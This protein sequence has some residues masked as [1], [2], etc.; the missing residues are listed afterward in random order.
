MRFNRSYHSLIAV[1]FVIIACDK[2]QQHE[3]ETKSKDLIG[4]WIEPVIVKVNEDSLMSNTLNKKGISHSE[5]VKAVHAN[6]EPYTGRRLIPL[7]FI[8]KHGRTIKVR[9]LLRVG[10]DFVIELPIES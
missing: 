7:R 6:I 4:N 1:S 8:E 9:S 3:L 10:Y 5:L 2:K